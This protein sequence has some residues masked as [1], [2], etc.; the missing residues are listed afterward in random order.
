VLG[1][2]WSADQVGR[3]S[4]KV[5]FGEYLPK[6]LVGRKI[7]GVGRWVGMRATHFKFIGE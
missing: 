3:C 6:M 4:H 1:V 5:G 7:D 2:Y